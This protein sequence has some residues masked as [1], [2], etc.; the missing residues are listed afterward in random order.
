MAWLRASNRK[1][2]KPWFD[3]RCGSQ[4]L[5]PWGKT[6]NTVFHFGAS[7]LPVSVA[8]SDKR[9]ANRAASVLG[10]VR[11]TQNIVHLALENGRSESKINSVLAL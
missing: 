7:S 1:V 8:Q 9:H 5:C 2:A 3:S 6:L 10:V 4:S 11:Q